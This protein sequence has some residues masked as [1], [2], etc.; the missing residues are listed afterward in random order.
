MTESNGELRVKLDGRYGN[1]LFI[2]Y[3]SRIFAEKNKL[4]LITNIPE[5]PLSIIDNKYFGIPPQNMERFVINDKDF[6]KDRNCYNYQG[7]GNYF[8]EGYFQIE[9]IIHEN[10][11]LVKSWINYNIN[12]KNIITLHVR[13]GDFYFPDSR[14]LIISQEYYVDCIKKY[15]NDYHDVYIICESIKDRW[16]NLYM[17]RLKE[18]IRDIGKNPIHESKSFK[19]DYQ[20]IIDSNIII[21][22]N[23]TFC[24]WPMLLSNADKIISFP[25]FGIDINLDN[26]LGYWS[27]NQKIFKYNKDSKYIFNYEYSNNI[28]NYFENMNNYK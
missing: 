21:T 6:N 9:D 23:S 1:K 12:K 13:L 11:D 25:Y 17:D 4:N 20:Y 5:G 8:F 26:S 28:I 27:G 15:G 3:N 7:P 19:D 18:K 2:Y 14:H 10:L 22:S 16:E 24:F